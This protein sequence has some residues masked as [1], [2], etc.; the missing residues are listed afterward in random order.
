MLSMDIENDKIKKGI[1][2]I[3]AYLDISSRD[4]LTDMIINYTGKVGLMKIAN[5]AIQGFADDLATD[6][7]E[8]K[9]ETQKALYALTDFIE[10]I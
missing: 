1:E 5:N 8:E 4:E 2:Y 10:E 3:R 9:K 7:E 6:T